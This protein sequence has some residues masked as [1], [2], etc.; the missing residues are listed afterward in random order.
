MLVSVMFGP[1]DSRNPVS[2]MALSFPII[3][4]NSRSYDPRHPLWR[5]CREIERID[6]Y[7]ESSD[8]CKTILSSTIWIVCADAEQYRGDVHTECQ[9]SPSPS[10]G[11]TAIKVS[12]ALLYPQPSA[13]SPAIVAHR[14]KR[15]AQKSIVDKSISGRSSDRIRLTSGLSACP[16]RK[17]VFPTVAY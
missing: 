2:S 16:S 4:R 13:S 15:S 14:P 1:F 3:R 11:G 6:D 12:P 7:D 9:I 17:C 8:D 10:D 5:E